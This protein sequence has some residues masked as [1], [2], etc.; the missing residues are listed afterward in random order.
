MTKLT[1]DYLT[2]TIRPQQTCE[3]A[4]VQMLVNLLTDIFHIDTYLD[5]FHVVGRSHY[6]S[7]IYRYN[8][9]QL[10]VCSP[11]KLYKQG[12]CLEFSGNGLALWVNSLPE[13]VTM[14]EVLRQF[15]SLSVCGFKINA[16]RLDVALDDIA[17]D[18]EKPILHMS[19]ISKKWADHE[20]CSRSR[21]NS[22]ET[23]KDFGRDDGFFKV[24]KDKINNKRGVIGRTIYFGNRKSSVYVRFYD[25]L[26]EQLQQGITV[27]SHIKSW[28]RCEYEY[29]DAK[30]ISILDMF[31]DHDYDTFVK[32]YKAVVLG[33]L[34]FINLDD[35]NR[36]RCSTCAW[37]TAFLDTLDGLQLSSG[38]ARTVQF[39]KTTSWIKRSVAPTLWAILSCMGVDFLEVLREE[40]RENI[41]ERQFQLIEDFWRNSEGLEHDCPNLWAYFAASNY[42]GYSEALEQLK[43]DSLYIKNIPPE[44]DK[45]DWVNMVFAGCPGSSL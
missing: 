9:I 18:Q 29:H 27:D 37:W 13:G 26:A 8:D 12:I 5:K 11:D 30:A 14:Q 22:D 31:I 44:M 17:K 19:T 40:G 2:V 21:A 43:K 7:A 1:L 34:R 42:G 39:R 38:P 20:F 45:R 4:T 41:K 25:K 35:S 6:Y 28:V 16:S 36:S 10:K 15:R 23:N 32:N 3:G 33:H 24:G